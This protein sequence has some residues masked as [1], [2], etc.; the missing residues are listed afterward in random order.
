MMHTLLSL[1][2]HKLE[3]RHVNVN[4]VRQLSTLPIIT[5]KINSKTIP[6]E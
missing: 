6:D 4:L 1:P 2:Y 5:A 3:P